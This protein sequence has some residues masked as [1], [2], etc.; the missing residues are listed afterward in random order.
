MQFSPYRWYFSSIS[1]F[2][3]GAL[4]YV[5]CHVTTLSQGEKITERRGER[6]ALIRT[7]DRLRLKL[8]GLQKASRICEIAALELGMRFPDERP[9][10]LYTAA[11]AASVLTDRSVTLRTLASADAGR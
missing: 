2:V 3:L 6:E 4:L 11:M 9:N 10:N 1:C 8:A 7:Q 5:W